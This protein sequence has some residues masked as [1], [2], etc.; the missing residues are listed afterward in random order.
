ME[1]EVAMERYE[2]NAFGNFAG[3]VLAYGLDDASIERSGRSRF[4][5]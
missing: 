3:L 4:V 2:T 1:R 5:L